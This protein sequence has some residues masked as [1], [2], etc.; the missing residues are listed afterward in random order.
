MIRTRRA[1]GYVRKLPSKRYQASHIGPDLVRHAAP[2][3]F[4]D[5]WKSA[6][7]PQIRRLYT[8]I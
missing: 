6:Y 3:T 2:D 8:S 7:R 4:P 1:F 5:A